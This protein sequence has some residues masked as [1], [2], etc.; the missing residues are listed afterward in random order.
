[1]G[2]ETLSLDEVFEL[3]RACNAIEIE[4]CTPHYFGDFLA[5][6]LAE[7][8]PKIST[9]VRRLDSY[10]MDRLCTAIKAVHEVIR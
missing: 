10:R 3:I 9:K 4:T 2:I 5:G 8:F 1:M 6:R 7:P